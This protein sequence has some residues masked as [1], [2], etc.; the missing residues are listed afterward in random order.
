MQDGRAWLIISM[1]KPWESCTSM[2]HLCYTLE[3]AALRLNLSETVLVR[4]S[5]YFKVP[6]SA[7]EEAGYLSFKGDLSFSDQDIEFFRQVRERLLAGESLEEVKARIRYENV[8]VPA[9]APEPPLGPQPSALEPPRQDV[10][11]PPV[12]HAPKSDY[13]TRPVSA[14][15][16]PPIREVV[17]RAPFEEAA[18]QSFD[19]YKQNHRYGL[20]RVF[21]NMLKEVGGSGRQEPSQKQPKPEKR[22]GLPGVKPLRPSIPEPAGWEES[23]PSPV[24][25]PEAPRSESL[26]PFR[27]MRQLRPRPHE[28]QPAARPVTPEPVHEQPQPVASRSAAATHPHETPATPPTEPA[29]ASMPVFSPGAPMWEE[30]LVQTTHHRALNNRLKDAATLMRERAVARNQARMQRKP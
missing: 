23:P 6:Q 14:A 30:R 19:R 12:A 10:P 13:Q 15:M 3:E 20:G 26:L 9:H 27:A 5:Q 22:L 2:T 25:E 16:T 8:T 17:D 1:R 28:A 7:Y 4:L 24:H 18:R 11:E 21:E 29:A